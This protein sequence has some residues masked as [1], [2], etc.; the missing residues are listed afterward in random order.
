MFDDYTH[1]H[2]FLLRPALAVA[3]ISCPLLADIGRRWQCLAFLRHI[4]EFLRRSGVWARRIAMSA[5]E[6]MACLDFL[7]IFRSQLARIRCSVSLNV[8][9]DIRANPQCF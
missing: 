5:I 7:A 6:K 1:Y 3:A 2:I 8:K 9:T 4:R